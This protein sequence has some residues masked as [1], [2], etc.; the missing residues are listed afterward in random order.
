MSD[1]T[2]EFKEAARSFGADLVGVASLDRFADVPPEHNPASISPD[3]KA[4]VVLGRRIT[5]GTVKAVEEGTNWQT[6]ELF[7]YHWLDTE[8][9]ALTTFESVEWLEDRGF[10]ACP[11]F[12][13]PP[14][15]PVQGIAVREGQPAPNVF[16]DIEQT[17]VAAGLGEIGWCGVLLT[18]Q[19]GPLQRL[20]MILTDAPL[21]ADPLFEGELCTKCGVCAAVCPLQAM[22]AEKE[23]TVRVAG[24]EYTV[25]SVNYDRCRRCQ[26]GARPNRYHGAGRPDRLAALCVRSCL[27]MLDDAGRLESKFEQPF[28]QREYWAI[29]ALGQASI[30]SDWQTFRGTGCADPSGFRAAD[31]GREQ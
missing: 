1:L 13:F 11:L 24:R 23:Q 31:E 8:F 28:R 19:F 9:L 6:Y 4:V 2:R 15:I 5:R 12:A 21:E 7:G 25:A 26:N 18:P 10:E 30:P 17:A 27:A 29:D 16:P 20:Q 22:D 14:E 3:A